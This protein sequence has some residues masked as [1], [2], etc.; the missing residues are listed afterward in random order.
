M[1]RIDTEEGKAVVKV[2]V[3]NRKRRWFH[4]LFGIMRRKPIEGLLLVDFEITKS[5][6]TCVV[7]NGGGHYEIWIDNEVDIK[8]HD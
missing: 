6:I 5:E 8:I 4:V 7:D 2:N 1:Q 3:I